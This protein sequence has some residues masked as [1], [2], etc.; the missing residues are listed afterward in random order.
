MSNP[1][2][3][4]DERIGEM[5]IALLTLTRL[6]LAS[7]GEPPPTLAASSWAFGLVGGIV[8]GASALGFGV[9]VAANL[10]VVLA[11]LV[12]IAI[13]IVV[14]GAM[15]ED[16]LADLADGFGGGH[17]PERKLAIMRDSQVGSYG[18]LALILAIALRALCI[19]AIEQPMVV[20]CA[21]IAIAVASRS[22]MVVV[23][24]AMPAARGDGLGRLAVG[25]GGAQ[26][27]VALASALG[28][29]CVLVAVPVWLACLV[30]M[31]I[32]GVGLSWLALR[33]IGGQT[34][35]VLGAAQQVTEIAGWIAIV[36]WTV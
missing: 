14:T 13:G 31:G 18:V 34:G 10:P 36:S 12:A 21:M 15:H 9:A 28:I 7:V 4:L 20:V 25:V 17:D 35:D 29:G 23:L 16:G 19:G 11:G 32:A 1:R 33:Q 2:Q 8:G 26:V 22:A 24:Y 30:A 27:T 3:W 5:R 6:P